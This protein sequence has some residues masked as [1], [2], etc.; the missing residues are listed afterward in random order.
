MGSPD[1]SARNV[2][3]A[4]FR[5][6]FNAVNTIFNAIPFTMLHGSQAQPALPFGVSPSA[7]ARFTLAF[8]SVLYGT[9]FPLGSLMNSSLPPSFC[10]SA[11]L[12]LSF[13]A[14][15]PFLPRLS[16]SLAKTA[17]LCG[18]ATATGYISQ[19]LSLVST[20]PSTVAF[21]GAAT[22]IVCPALEALVDKRPMGIRS[23]PQT[24]LAGLLCLSGVAV[25][26]LWNPG[27]GDETGEKLG[28]GM[29]EPHRRT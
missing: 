20:P 13:V 3:S 6:I 29:D 21:L 23:A 4:T 1:A 18:A 19:S 11:R 9:N 25:L 8:A 2:F 7:A 12:F 15:S 17:T 16:P 5:S 14:L 26:E 28:V 22:V 27:S 10:T 24:Y